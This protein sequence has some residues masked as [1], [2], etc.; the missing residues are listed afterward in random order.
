M[1]SIVLQDAL[2]CLEVVEDITA[3][4]A[5]MGATRSKRYNHTA[6]NT[7]YV[8]VLSVVNSMLADA[9]GE[10]PNALNLAVTLTL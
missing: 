4:G 1:H 9:V 7:L 8:R 3:R 5:P 10:R 2:T 6:M